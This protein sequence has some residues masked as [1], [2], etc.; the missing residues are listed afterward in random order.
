[1]R[2]LEKSQGKL[3][4]AERSPESNPEKIT[5]DFVFYTILYV[6]HKSTQNLG[7]KIRLL[8]GVSIPECLWAPCEAPTSI[9]GALKGAVSLIIFI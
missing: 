3:R 1:M 4:K 9:N 5:A 8:C 7:G 2:K 6:S